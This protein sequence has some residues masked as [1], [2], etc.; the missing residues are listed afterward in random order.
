MTEII[1]AW[2]GILAQSLWTA[3]EKKRVMVCDRPDGFV[4][5]KGYFIVCQPQ[6]KVLYN[7]IWTATAAGHP[8]DLFWIRSRHRSQEDEKS[9]MI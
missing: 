2:T 1:G 4:F 9:F 3:D 7:Q 5:F 8:H 6:M